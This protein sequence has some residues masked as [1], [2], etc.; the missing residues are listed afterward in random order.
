MTAT[1]WGAFHCFHVP[2][3]GK[4]LGY[5]GVCCLN[6]ERRNINK[7]KANIELVNVF[8]FFYPEGHYGVWAQN[9]VSSC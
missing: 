1:T 7:G 8:F 9:P 6:F 3:L 2:S 5:K 4:R